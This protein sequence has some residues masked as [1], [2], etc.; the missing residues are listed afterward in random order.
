MTKKD[1][2]LQQSHSIDEAENLAE[3]KKGREDEI[4]EDPDIKKKKS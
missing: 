2:S 4:I 3:I 1:E